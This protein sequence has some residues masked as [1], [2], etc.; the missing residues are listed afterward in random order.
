M[1]EVL[2]SVYLEVACI[3]VDVVAVGNGRHG[4]WSRFRGLL[5]RRSHDL[6][7]LD[8]WT[9]RPGAATCIRGTTADGEDA[10]L[11]TGATSV[12]FGASDPQAV[13]VRVVAATRAHMATMLRTCLIRS[14]SPVAAEC[15]TS[16]L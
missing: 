16:E 15:I 6:G 4:R 14:S 8:C 1:E 11:V 7:S 12:L 13:R 3:D 2:A 9:V 10:A 5:Q